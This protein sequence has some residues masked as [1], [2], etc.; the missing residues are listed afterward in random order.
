M[1]GVNL[2]P[3]DTEPNGF[4]WKKKTLSEEVTGGL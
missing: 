4:C 1:P 2:R 3:N